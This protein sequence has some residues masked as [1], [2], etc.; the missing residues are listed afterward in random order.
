MKIHLVFL[1]CCIVLFTIYGCRAGKSKSVADSLSTNT[2]LKTSGVV[3]TKIG[4]NECYPVI[5]VSNKSENI[6]LIP[7]P[8]LDSI[9]NKDGLKI[10]FDYKLLRIKNPDGCVEGIPAEIYNIEIH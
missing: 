8:P 9:Y 10:S 1:F 5:R 2:D 3:A 6:I 4:E 7:I